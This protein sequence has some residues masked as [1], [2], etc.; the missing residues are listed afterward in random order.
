[1]GLY[2][3]AAAAAAA[4]VPAVSRRGNA[5]RAGTTRLAGEGQTR[6]RGR[7]LLRGRVAAPA[8]SLPLLLNGAAAAKGGASMGPVA[9][10]REMLPLPIFGEAARAV[11]ATR[12][13]PQLLLRRGSRSKSR[14]AGGFLPE[15]RGV[16][17]LVVPR[18]SPES[19][20]RRLQQ[21]LGR[22][23]RLPNAG[24][25][26]GIGVAVVEW[27]GTKGRELPR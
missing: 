14:R 10:V 25:V 6:G 12:A 8:P 26:A 2:V 24:V 23:L 7:P 21:Q 5:S 17:Q 1:M 15:G 3:A 27:P 4:A 22:G 18:S 16:W 11:P 13:A 19:R 20:R 9:A